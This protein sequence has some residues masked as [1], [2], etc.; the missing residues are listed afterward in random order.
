MR[1]RLIAIVIAACA[2]VPAG[3]APAPQITDPAGDARVPVTG[4][5]IVSATFSTAGTTAKVRGKSVYTPTKL[6]VAVTYSGDV[7]TDP[8]ATHAVVFNAPTCSEIYLQ[9][10]SGGTYGATGCS[11]ATFEFTSAV[12]GHTLTFTVPFATIG[13]QYLKPGTTLTDLVVYSAASEPL[14]GYES[15]ELSSAVPGVD[16]AIDSATT[17]ASFRIR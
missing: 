16:G 15:R 17:T 6:V 8:Y 3:A 9:V 10:Y 5:D 7:T 11:S 12:S 4:M 2:A 13:K 14:F 1:T